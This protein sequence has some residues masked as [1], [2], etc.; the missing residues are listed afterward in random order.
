[1][2]RDYSGKIINRTRVHHPPFTFHLH[3]LRRRTQPIRT[4]WQ[5]SGH[6]Y[7]THTE[8]L[9]QHPFSY[10]RVNLAAVRLIDP[11]YHT[12]FLTLPF[13]DNLLYSTRRKKLEESR[14]AVL[15]FARIRD[16]KDDVWC[17]FLYRIIRCSIR[18]FFFL[19]FRE[20]I[21]LIEW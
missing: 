7:S 21:I 8:G 3:H 10:T 19:I 20:K 6:A 16:Q 14:F 11:E 18:P 4:S 12:S 15:W 2:I 13:P 17:H 9:V 1:M 5:R